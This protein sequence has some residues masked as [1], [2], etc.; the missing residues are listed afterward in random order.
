MRRGVVLLLALLALGA[1]PADGALRWSDPQAL[2]EPGSTGYVRVA[3]DA[4]GD[5]LVV[6]GQIRNDGQ[7]YG[8]ILYRWRSPRGKWTPTR[9]IPIPNIG[10]L[11]VGVA[12]TPLGEAVVVAAH[13]R[14]GVFSATA[15]PGREFTAPRPIAP[16]DERPLGVTLAI[17]DAGNGAATWLSQ[18]GGRIRVATRRPGAG[19]GE[20]VTIAGDSGGAVPFVAMND[21]G[22]AVVAWPSSSETGLRPFASYRPPAGSFGPPEQVQVEARGP[23]FHPSV[24]PAGGVLLAFGET[25][26][27]GERAETGSSYAVRS[28]LGGWGPE[29]VI[30]T[31]GYVS[32]AFAEPTGAV[33]FLIDVPDPSGNAAEPRRYV[34]FASRLP[35]GML[36]GPTQ[37]SKDKGSSPD[38][39]M[40]LRGDILAAWSD[41]ADGTGRVTVA[42][43]PVG[44]VFTEPVAISDPKTFGASV[45]FNDALQAVVAWVQ[46]PT[47]NYA[48]GSWVEVA[49]RED[50]ALPTLPFPPDVDLGAPLDPILD[51]DGIAVPVSCDVACTVEPTGL[52]F[53]KRQ[54]TARAKT[55]GRVKVLAGRRRDV[56]V[57]FGA[58]ARRAA[59]KALA[60]G[61][62]PWVAFT[63]RAKGRSPRP[64]A[65]SRRVPL[66]RSRPRP[67][68]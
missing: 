37:I 54:A 65:F 24:D 42:D 4:R 10:L 53:D 7:G 46:T 13:Q 2:S 63:V 56:R 30:D 1:A 31:G 67:R 36:R 16:A 25:I 18:P 38:G 3:T 9:A 17:D 32:E 27:R 61:R 6:W 40:N 60:D 41:Q 14:T 21:A 47:P 34:R 49:V 15:R 23:V 51:G 50:L 58:T 68:P 52:L 64:V 59:R 44:T 5:S 19:F 39:A 43:R 55:A 28:P 35:T 26:Y 66:E 12:M 20:P 45:A 48:V 33:S 62:K 29:Q 22:A 8:E 11:S 57:R